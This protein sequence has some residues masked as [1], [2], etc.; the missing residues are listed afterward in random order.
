MSYIVGK[1]LPGICRAWLFLLASGQYSFPEKMY[2]II[3]FDVIIKHG[4]DTRSPHFYYQKQKNT[5]RCLKVTARAG[6][7]AWSVAE[8]AN[9]GIY[10]NQRKW[11]FNIKCVLSSNLTNL[12]VMAVIECFW[13]PLEGLK[14][15]LS[16]PEDEDWELKSTQCND[17][18]T[19]GDYHSLSPC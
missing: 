9:L 5:S 10:I 16:L 11:I 7:V 17:R 3:L 14:T 18:Q 12:N 6:H 1:L 8:G 13:R 2:N 15:A 19:D 4:H